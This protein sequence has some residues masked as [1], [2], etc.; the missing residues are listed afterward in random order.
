[1][2]S[3]R[4]PIVI[5]LADDNEEHRTPAGDATAGNSVL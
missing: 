5:Q 1:M 4:K 2:R 3:E